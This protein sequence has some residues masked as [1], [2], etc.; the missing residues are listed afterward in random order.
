[1]VGN[2]RGAN[3]DSVFPLLADLLQSPHPSMVR[4]MKWLTENGKVLK[5][6]A[7]RE[8]VV[9]NTNDWCNRENQD[10]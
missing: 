10:F 3:G 7:S 4:L 5:V 6:N 2:T 8:L 1:M 9:D